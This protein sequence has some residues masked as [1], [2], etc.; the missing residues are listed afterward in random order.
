MIDVEVVSP[1]QTYFLEVELNTCLDF[2]TV[3]IFGILLNLDIRLPNAFTPNGDGVND[4]FRLI[5]SD[6]F[7]ALILKIYNGWGE[8]IYRD[9]GEN[10]TWFG[11]YQ[12]DKK[13][14]IGT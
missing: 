14:P 12:N 8:L 9:E 2:D 1:V 6:E 3:T 11:T 10:P 4:V 5:N 7:E 13:C